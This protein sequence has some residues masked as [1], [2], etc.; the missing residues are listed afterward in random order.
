MSLES[1]LS[2]VF[3]ES[4]QI[5]IGKLMMRPAFCCSR[6]HRSSGAQMGFWKHSLG[7]S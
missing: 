2:R 7:K 6:L 4:R 5:P 3:Q 1:D